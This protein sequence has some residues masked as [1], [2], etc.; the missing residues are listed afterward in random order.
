MKLRHVYA[1]PTLERARLCVDEARLHGLDDSEIALVAHRDIALERIPDSLRDGSA[2][3][4][5]PALLRG[6]AGGG[7][8][9]VLAGLIALAIPTAGVTLAGAGLLAAAGA[10]VGTWSGALIGSAVPNAVHRDYERRLEAGEIL[11]VLDAE[12]EGL[13][14][15]DAR[16]A[17][18]GAIQLDYEQPAALA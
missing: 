14:L 11:I 4:F 1:T 17:A 9:G 6:A 18:R 8:V 16:M 2:T 12:E 10:A 3:D 7:S 15:L 5:V 13:A